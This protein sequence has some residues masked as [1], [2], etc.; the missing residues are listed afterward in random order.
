MDSESLEEIKNLN[1]R[2]ALS[3]H[4]LQQILQKLLKIEQLLEESCITE[5]EIYIFLVSLLADIKNQV[6]I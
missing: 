5:V 3:T 2:C 4:N 1:I 6:V